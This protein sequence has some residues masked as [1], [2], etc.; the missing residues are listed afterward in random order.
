M[1][2]CGTV[3]SSV[4]SNWRSDVLER[5]NIEWESSMGLAQE[6]IECIDRLQVQLS[7]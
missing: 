6:G 2:H 7:E 5:A 4:Q 3:D 1:I